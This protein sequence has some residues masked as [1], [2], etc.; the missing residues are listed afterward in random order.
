MKQQG[1]NERVDIE[2][3]KFNLGLLFLS[4]YSQWLSGTA[5]LH[6]A[7]CK[8]A[9]VLQVFTT[10]PYTLAQSR[11]A[12]VTFMDCMTAASVRE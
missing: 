7:K 11:G 12:E 9:P 4:C 6:E 2:G 8:G 3:V 5:V 1:D 10:G